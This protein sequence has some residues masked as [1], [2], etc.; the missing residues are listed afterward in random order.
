MTDADQTL[1]YGIAP[2][3]HRLSPA[4][5]LAG[6][7]LHVRDLTRS[8][9]YYESVL[10]LRLARR[11]GPRA[12][13]TAYGSDEA[14]VTLHESE[15]RD[16]A[17]IP[18]RGRL[19][20]FHFAI[21]LPDLTALGGLLAHLASTNERIGASDHLVSEAIY[22]TDPDGLGIEVYADRPRDTWRHANRQLEM[23]SDPLD[24]RALVR[25]AGDV[26]W[27]GMP[28]GTVMGHLHLHVGDLARAE[29][30]YHQAL[31]FDKVVWSYP[32]ALFL[33]AGGYHHH[34]GLNTW[35]AGAPPAGERD[36]RLL[37][38]E[39]VLPTAHDIDGA[40]ASVEAAGGTVERAPIALVRDPWGTTLHLRAAN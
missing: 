7:H 39:V 33:S 8:V 9:A 32:G 15:R 22:L 30:F 11:D 29:A 36:A 23:A 21:L 34:L 10:G 35:A 26:R 38:W 40:L 25:D 13:L 27:T 37:A 20:L 4:L 12:T 1:P 31:G 19:G 3:A 24:L 6:V 14:L 18:P 17:P 5:R 2:N 28:H 16:A